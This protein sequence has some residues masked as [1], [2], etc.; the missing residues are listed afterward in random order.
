MRILGILIDDHLDFDFYNGRCATYQ[1]ANGEDRTLL[2]A[3]GSRKEDTYQ[4]CYEY[5][6]ESYYQIGDTRVSHY[7]GEMVA[8]RDGIVII[9]GGSVS[10]NYEGLSEVFSPETRGWSDLTISETVAW[11]TEFASVNV[12]GN[13][14]VFGEPLYNIGCIKFYN[15]WAI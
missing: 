13:V 4:N 8:Y 11:L 9:A 14:F 2:C 12:D 6:G 3:S 5:D 1:N 15:R 7:Q 10:S